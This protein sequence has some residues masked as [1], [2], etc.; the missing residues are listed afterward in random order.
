MKLPRLGLALIVNNVGKESPGSIAD[1]KAL[2][3]AYRKIGFDVEIHNNCS[4][5]VNSLPKKEKFINRIL[6]KTCM[7]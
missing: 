1:V 3:S 5:T 2:E 7:L 4:N 6:K